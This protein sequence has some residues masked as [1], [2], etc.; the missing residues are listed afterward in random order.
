MAPFLLI[1]PIAM[2]AFVQNYCSSGLSKGTQATAVYLYPTAARSTGVGWVLGVSRAGA[3]IGPIIVGLL[4]QMGWTP[5]QVFQACA[6][7]LLLGA[8]ALYLAKRQRQ[9]TEAAQAAS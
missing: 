7:P 5:A 1:T 8:A 2:A 6:G 3:L 4:L 9:R